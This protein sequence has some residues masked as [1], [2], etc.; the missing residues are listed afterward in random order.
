MATQPPGHGGSCV[1]STAFLP[2][3]AFLACR[4][5]ALASDVA[6][7]ARTQRATTHCPA[8]QDYWLWALVPICPASRLAG[9]LGWLHEVGEASARPE[10]SCR[11]GP[12]AHFRT[13]L[14]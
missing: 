7:T 10:W 9:R 12:A 1:R 8:S 4:A 3:F 11:E 5:G 13:P 2:A 14:S 6:T